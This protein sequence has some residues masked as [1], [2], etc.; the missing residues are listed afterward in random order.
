MSYHALLD[1]RLGMSLLRVMNDSSY[2]AGADGN[3]NFVE[4]RD[5]S[6]LAKGWLD[7][8]NAGFGAAGQPLGETKLLG[9]GLSQVPVL[10]WG[11]VKN[12]KAALVVHP[13]WDLSNLEDNG[14]LAEV[15]REAHGLTS[16]SGTVYF[17]DSFN[18]SRR[19]GRCYEWL[20]RAAVRVAAPEA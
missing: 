14:W 18:L 9:A 11:P 15:L 1:W 5:W 16:G 17:I 3:F 7:S 13:F 8:F 19:P 10:S 12:R 20:M 4:L 6:G 2:V